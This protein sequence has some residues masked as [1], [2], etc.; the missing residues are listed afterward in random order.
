[1]RILT[2]NQSDWLRVAVDLDIPLPPN[3]LRSAFERLDSTGIRRSV[4]NSFYFIVSRRFYICTQAA[5][6]F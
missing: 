1:L 4:H 6:W 5:A 2:G 3:E